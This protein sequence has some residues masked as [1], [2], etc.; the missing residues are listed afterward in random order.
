MRSDMFWWKEWFSPPFRT[1]FARQVSP[2]G[3]EEVVGEFFEPRGVAKRDSFL[4][5]LEALRML[6]RVDGSRTCVP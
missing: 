6:G 2:R 4:E 3:V 1:Y 5:N